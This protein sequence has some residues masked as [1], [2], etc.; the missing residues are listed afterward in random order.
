MK[1]TK[2]AKL[3]F[4][5]KKINLTQAKLAKKIGVERYR[6]ADWEQ[7]RSEPSLNNLIA[8]SNALEISIEKLLDADHIKISESS[9]ENI[10][11]IIKK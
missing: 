8:L 4:Y 9:D 6:I 5:R 3:E 2:L 11:S 10:L 1:N 7:G